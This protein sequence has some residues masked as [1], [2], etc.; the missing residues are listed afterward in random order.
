MLG[1]NDGI[2]STA[3]LEMNRVAAA[4]AACSCIFDAGGQAWSPGAISMAAGE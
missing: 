1:A 3:Y 4:N 2:V